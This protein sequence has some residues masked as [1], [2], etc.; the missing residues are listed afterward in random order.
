MAQL[1]K[2]SQSK[3][4]GATGSSGLSAPAAKKSKVESNDKRRAVPV[5]AKVVPV[6]ESEVSD[7]EDWED[8]QEL[9][10]GDEQVNEGP[11]TAKAPKDPQEGH[12]AQKELQAQRR[13]SKPHS[14]LL[15]E[16]KRVWALARKIDIP[17]AERQKHIEELMNVLRGNVQD[18]VFKHDASRIVQT[19][20]KYGGQKERDEVAAEL[21]GKYRD[22]AQN[23]YGKGGL[24]AALEHAAPERRKRI[25]AS[26][27]ETLMQIFNNPDKGAVS[28]SIVH[29]VLWEYLNEL[30]L[31]ED[32]DKEDVERL[33][34]ELFD[35]C[36]ELL[37][38]MVHT[39]DGSRAVR[40]F[41]ARG[42]D[43]KQIIKTLKPHI[44]KICGDEEAQLVL[45][46]IFDLVETPRHFTPALLRTISQTDFAQ[47]TTSKKDPEIRRAELRAAASPGMVKAIEDDAEALVRDRGA[48]VF[49]GEVMLFA[50]GALDALLSPISS[51]Y[52]PPD[53]ES[54]LSDPTITTHIL[55]LS[56]ASRLYKT[57]VQG[58][59]YNQQTKSIE[60]SEQAPKSV[61]KKFMY[62]A[63]K[64]NV[65]SMALGEGGFIVA[66]VVGKLKDEGDYDDLKEIRS[67][68]K[69]DAR[70]KLGKG[71][72]R[73]SWGGGGVLSIQLIV[74]LAKGG[75][76]R[77]YT[78]VVKL[79]ASA[80]HDYSSPGA[81]AYQK[82]VIRYHPSLKVQRPTIPYACTCLSMALNSRVHWTNPGLE[83]V[84]PTLFHSTDEVG[85]MTND[86]HSYLHNYFYTFSPRPVEGS[87]VLCYTHRS[88][89]D[90]STAPVDADMRSS[91]A[92]PSPDWYFAP[93]S[94]S[95]ASS[96]EPKNHS[97]VTVIKIFCTR[98][99]LLMAQR[100]HHSMPPRM[101]PNIISPTVDLNDNPVKIQQRAHSIARYL[102]LAYTP[103]KP[104]AIVAGALYMLAA[105]A[106]LAWFSRHRDASGSLI[107]FLFIAYSDDLHNM[108]LYAA[109]DYL[110]LISISFFLFGAYTLLGRLAV[111][112]DA[113]E[114]LVIKPD[115]LT[116]L[117]MASS[118]LDI[119]K[120][121]SKLIIAGILVQFVGLAVYL[122][123]LI[124]F[125]YRIWSRRKEQW[126]NRPNGFLG[127]WLG[128]AA[129][130]GVC[131]QNLMIPLIYRVT[132]I[133]LGR[134]GALSRK[135]YYFY[136]SEVMTL[137]GGVLVIFL[138]AWPPRIFSRPCAKGQ[139]T[140]L[141]LIS[142][143]SK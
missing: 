72:I 44:E 86:Q 102:A 81:G 133:G 121:G 122:G 42:T 77:L 30:T 59:H 90:V 21:K 109:M 47:G 70:D 85:G 1:K 76:S 142:S 17:R 64:E 129:M 110:I 82:R 78:M 58:G 118:A 74:C 93:L 57:L 124:N 125:V 36:Q 12:K 52:A 13:A 135:E 63:G 62:V 65:V 48:S 141:S 60:R 67:W 91:D 56:H 3:K 8:E 69:K 11:L 96:G 98:C 87:D 143:G 123:L 22:L 112:L 34:R 131:C 132:A 68:F 32:S 88:Q 127:N 92:Y 55:N 103:N 111:H 15:V 19:L 130:T 51:P 80:Y 114:L 20:V 9:E 33:R 40:E 95:E 29:R 66:E 4:R 138:M 79:K 35:T 117:L 61:P 136:T 71:D 23:K 53:P 2:S 137:W 10:S 128:V 5:T 89:G 119:I 75:C 26:V 43:R 25:L 46:T 18:I 105:C 99:V 106:M 84:Q 49:V 45:F 126:N 38:E 37:A 31:L 39:K 97:T 116:N 14:A 120:V 50:Q 100:A 101:K 24:R 115:L 28:H 108:S 54:D 16:A 73:G 104:V 83:T 6:V 140:E 41:I 107:D 94:N 134:N 113:V 139:M 7:E 27:A